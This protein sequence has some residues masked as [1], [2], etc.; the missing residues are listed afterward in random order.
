MADVENDLKKMV[1][2]GWRKTDRDRQQV[3]GLEG[4][5]GRHEPYPQ[6]GDRKIYIHHFKSSVSVVAKAGYQLNV[7]FRTFS[8]Y[9][10]RI[11][12]YLMRQ[13]CVICPLALSCRTTYKGVVQ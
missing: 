1:N 13:R 5:Q 12:I 10:E 8:F 2:R 9:W 6:G 3:I 4:G 11:F 7:H